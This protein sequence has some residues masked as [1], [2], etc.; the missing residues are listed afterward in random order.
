L[1]KQNQK[2]FYFTNFSRFF[3]YPKTADLFRDFLV[4]WAKK[5]G[6]IGGGVHINDALPI[7]PAPLIGGQ[8]WYD[9]VCSIEKI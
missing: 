9:N 4:W 1:G 3:R 2:I 8:N 5:R 6:G 7:N